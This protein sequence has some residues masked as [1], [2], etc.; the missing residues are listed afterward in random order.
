MNSNAKILIVEDERIPAEFLK[1]VLLQD[2]FEVAGICDTGEKAIAE[3][4]RV[5][6]DVIFMDI[7]LKDHI[8]GAEAALKI[9]NS[10]ETKI[11]FLTAY[12]D[13]EMIEYALDAGAVNYL[14]KPYKEKQIQAALQL[15]LGHTKPM[16]TKTR[17]KGM[18]LLQNDYTFDTIQNRLYHQ[19][20]E[21]NLG[22]QTLKLLT[23][24]VEHKNKTV[25]LHDLTTYVYGKNRETSSIRTLIFRLKKTLGS[26]I[27]TNVSGIGYKISTL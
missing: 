18:V 16:Q 8:S 6:P 22:R 11:I 21:V 25:S 7:M 2:G 27:I 12:S 1:K 10:I 3:A 13:D 19:D 4:I 17:E 5:K 20:K 24:L 23:Y 26:E 15:A 9:S 14:I